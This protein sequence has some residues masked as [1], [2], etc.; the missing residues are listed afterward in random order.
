MPYTI[1]LTIS[2]HDMS[3]IR[4][5]TIEQSNLRKAELASSVS[6]IISGYWAV[7]II[8]FKE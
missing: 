7:Q 5:L 8:L 6:D 4:G 1:L 3:Y 2:Y